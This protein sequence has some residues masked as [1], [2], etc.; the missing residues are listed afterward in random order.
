MQRNFV[1]KGK[2]LLFFKLPS[3]KLFP[4]ASL[5]LLKQKSALLF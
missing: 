3:E 5:A 2:K 4:Q 1:G